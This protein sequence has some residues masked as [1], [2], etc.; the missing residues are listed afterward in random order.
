MTY[1]VMLHTHNYF[2]LQSIKIGIQATKSAIRVA[3]RSTS[4]KTCAIVHQDISRI[5][6]V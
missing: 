2:T 3:N 1:E 4:T 5:R 6:Y